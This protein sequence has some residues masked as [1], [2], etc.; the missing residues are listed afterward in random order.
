MPPS[1]PGAS[2]FAAGDV[3]VIDEAGMLGTRLMADLA[4]EADRANAKIDPRRRPEAAPA[5]RGRRP[6]RAP[7]ATGSA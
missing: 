4:E 5:D 6:V 2:G 7:R 3:L 1:T